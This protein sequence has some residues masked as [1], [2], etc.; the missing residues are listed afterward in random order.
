MATR[1]IKMPVKDHSEQEIEEGFS[2]RKPR[3]QSLSVIPL[4]HMLPKAAGLGTWC[5][6]VHDEERRLLQ[7]FDYPRLLEPPRTK[8]NGI[9]LRAVIQGNVARFV[10]HDNSHCNAPKRMVAAHQRK[11]TR[12][13]CR[14]KFPL[15]AAQKKSPAL[16]ATA[17]G[18][19][20]GLAKWGL[21]CLRVS[22]QA[23]PDLPVHWTIA[24]FPNFPRDVS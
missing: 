5:R 2:Q 22:I 19:G 7:S 21:P 3:D 15:A 18:S 11:G 8:R 10:I 16:W 6:G 12:K 9:H 14:A 1:Q 23:Q 4:K 20:V 24:L 13:S 17:R